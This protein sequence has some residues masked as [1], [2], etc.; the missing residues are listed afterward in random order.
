MCTCDGLSL[1]PG[2]AASQVWSCS[3]QGLRKLRP[4]SGPLLLLGG[5]RLQGTWLMRSKPGARDCVTGPQAWPA[6][7]QN[8]GLTAGKTVL[9]RAPLWCPGAFAPVSARLPH[10]AQRASCCLSLGPEVP[11]GAT[12]PETCS[13][14]LVGSAVHPGLAPLLGSSSL[15]SSA[16]IQRGAWPARHFSVTHVSSSSRPL[17]PGPCFVHHSATQC[18]FRAQAGCTQL[19]LVLLRSWP[20]ASVLHGPDFLRFQGL[21]GW[22]GSRPALTLNRLLEVPVVRPPLLS[23]ACLPPAAPPP[24]RAAGCSGLT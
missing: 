20:L 22:V 10:L 18:S 16:Q 5:R 17:L 3:G 8:P 21:S 15:R 1:A 12:P 6:L 11:R 23:T 14:V 19:K 2:L 13:S 24:P 9:K 7:R 4:R